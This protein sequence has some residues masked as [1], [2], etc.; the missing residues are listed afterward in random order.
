MRHVHQ[1][2]QEGRPVEEREYSKPAY[3]VTVGVVCERCNNTWMS[4]LESRGK[5]YLQPML[6]H[7][8]RLLYEGGQRTLATWALKTSMMIEHLHGPKRRFIAD[9]EYEHLFTHREPSERIRI[10]MASYQGSYAVAVGSTGAFDVQM[11]GDVYREWAPDGGLRDVWA[12]TILFG[13]VVFQVSGTT[14]PGLLEGVELRT[15]NTHRIWPHQRS[16]TWTPRPG[17]NEE[18]V[19]GL[20]DI[21]L[22]EY[23]R[24]VRAHRLERR[25]SR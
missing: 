19:V 9:E 13:P 3:S 24:R 7:H 18:Q 8:G 6:E 15:M 17:F 22:N 23:R 4:D 11:A 16:F 20:A 10:W 25:G 21:T 14:I 1:I 5:G 2:F 12:V